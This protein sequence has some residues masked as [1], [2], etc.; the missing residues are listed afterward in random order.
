TILTRPG[1]SAWTGQFGGNIN[2]SAFNAATPG[3]LTKPERE[4]KTFNSTLGG[5]FIPKILTATF[6]GQYNQTDAEGNAIRAVL[7]FGQTV[8]QGVMSPVTRRNGG[9]RGQLYL[10]K[11]NTLNFNSLYTSTHSNNQ[12]VGGFNLAER[13]FNSSSRAWQIQLSEF[14]VV[15]TSILNEFRF[16]A[17]ENDQE[18]VSVSNTIA[19][20]VSGAFN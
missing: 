16:Q 10:S 1:T 20:N 5:A 11:N 15:R 17:G 14:A 9:V 6:T 13:A 2:S 3:S 7:P 18:N 8:N 4:T 12:G 19:I